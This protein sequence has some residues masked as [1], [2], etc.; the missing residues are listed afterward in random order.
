MS[1]VQG[2]EKTSH[3]SQRGKGQAYADQQAWTVVGAFDDL[4]VSAIKMSPWER[5]DLQEW[6]GDRAGEWDALIFAKT[7]RVFRSAADCVRL[8]EWCREHHKILVL[9]DDGIRLDYYHPED[10]KDVFAGAMSKVFLILASVFAEIEG[11][12]FVQRA[13]DRVAFL[14]G[15]DRWGYGIPPFGFKIV[16]HPSGKGKALDLDPEAQKVLSG[17]VTQ[18]LAGDS[19]TG[20]TAR[21]NQDK[22]MSPRD[23]VR[24]RGGKPPAGTKWT[25]NRL[26]DILTNPSTQGIKTADGRPVLDAQGEPVRVGPASLDRE[27]WTRLQ[28]EIAQRSGRPR[29]RRHTTNPLLGVAKC[30]VCKK[31][32]R[33]RSQTTPAGVTHRYYVCG[34]SPRSCPAVS[35]IAADAEAL[36]Y[37]EFLR[38]HA[39]RRVKVRSWSAGSDPSA[40][41]DQV[42]ATIAALREDRALGLFT[43]PADEDMFRG[44]MQALVVRRETLSKLPVSRAGWVD[45]ELEETYGQRWPAATTDER[46]RL[47]RDTDFT[48][49]VYRDRVVETYMDEA[50][51]GL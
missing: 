7:D 13:R 11:Q 45:V 51:V 30:G 15:T 46:R 1:S 8:A 37:E 43:T 12:R 38:V 10:A 34:N 32:M 9:V 16:D 21:L 41:L 44:Q 49:T 18:F 14:R 40:E 17:V 6:L 26:K 50:R 5:P 35:A 25:M 4:D 33:Q 20:I 42:N 39:D 31:N 48:I 27:T 19:L 36:V 24:R 29:E 47:L 28:D 3:L 2:Q 23:W 22:V